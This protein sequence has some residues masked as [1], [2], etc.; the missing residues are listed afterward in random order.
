MI[1][2]SG[3]RIHSLF[4]SR[5]CRSNCDLLPFRHHPTSPCSLWVLYYRTHF[6]TGKNRSYNLLTSA[7]LVWFLYAPG[8][9]EISDVIRITACK[10][11][12]SHTKLPSS[13]DVG[14]KMPFRSWEIRVGLWIGV[15]RKG[16][17]QATQQN[18]PNLEWIETCL[19]TQS[20]PSRDPPLSSLPK[21][22]WSITWHACN[23]KE[24]T[25]TMVVLLPPSAWFC[26]LSRCLSSPAPLHPLSCGITLANNSL[27][28][29][30]A[31]ANGTRGE[32]S[33]RIHTR[34]GN[35]V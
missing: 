10:T 21:S 23:T 18:M 30:F 26:I 15:S 6:P 9:V 1:V 16:Y 25:A 35:F 28:S 33:E 4:P 17:I 29:K 31:P 5:R 14:F 34:E 8:G 12:M 3:N 2:L 22:N 27:T 13:G 24:Q 11:L 7:Q 20:E 32:Q 19:C